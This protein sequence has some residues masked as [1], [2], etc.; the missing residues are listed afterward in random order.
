M[1]QFTQKYKFLGQEVLENHGFLIPLTA[2][3]RLRRLRNFEARISDF[4]P[5]IYTTESRE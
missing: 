5:K 2:R 1:G 3:F 4:Y